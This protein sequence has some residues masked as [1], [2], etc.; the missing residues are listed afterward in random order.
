MRAVLRDLSGVLERAEVV[1]PDTTIRGYIGDQQVTFEI[2]TEVESDMTL[3]W[4]EASVPIHAGLE[5]LLSVRPRTRGDERDVARGLALDLR[6]GDPV[7]DVAFIVEGAPERL[8]REILDE[9]VRRQL[10]ALK[11]THVTTR[12]IGMLIHMSEWVDDAERAALLVRTT[13]RLGALC[14]EIG[15]RQLADLARVDTSGYRGGSA[16]GW[17][18][19]DQEELQALS[20][21]M[22]RRGEL[23][24]REGRRYRRMF[25]GVLIVIV[26]MVVALV[27]IAV[28]TSQ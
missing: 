6:L 22:E 18:A 1:D 24:E 17:R 25:T 20:R 23:R 16:P 26:L 9:E 5:L 8:V 7:F 2:K 28:T 21:S 10:L 14:A 27:G 12:R 4:T 19:R 13:A 11:P 15:R 3:D